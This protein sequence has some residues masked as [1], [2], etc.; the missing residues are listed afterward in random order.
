MFPTDLLRTVIASG[1]PAADHEARRLALRATG[2]IADPARAAE[3]HDMLTTAL[4]GLGAATA[5]G[6]EAME[7]ARV[8]VE[9][10]LAKIDAASQ[11]A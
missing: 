6:E 10:V 9:A 2:S 11:P 1:G 8:L 7:D 5:M 3:L 4:A